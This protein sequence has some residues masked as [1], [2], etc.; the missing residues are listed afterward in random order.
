MLSLQGDPSFFEHQVALCEVSKVFTICL[1][2]ILDVRILEKD[3]PAG[4][5]AYLF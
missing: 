1:T 5:E 2:D 3:Q 4:I